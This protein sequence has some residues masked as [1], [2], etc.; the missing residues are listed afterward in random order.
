MSARLGLL[1]SVL[2]C[3]CC[4]GFGGGDELGERKFPIVFNVPVARTSSKILLVEGV[5][6]G[7][8]GGAVDE[9]SFCTITLFNPANLLPGAATASAVL[10]VGSVNL[11]PGA[12]TAA[13]FVLSVLCFP[14]TA[15]VVLFFSSTPGCPLRLP[16]NAIVAFVAFV[17]FFTLVFAFTSAFTS[18]FALP[19]LFVFSTLFFFS[20]AASGASTTA[21]WQSRPSLR[22][23]AGR[24]KSPS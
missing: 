19:A 13:V 2:G 21:P 9:S 18:V 20:T 6:S 3:C 16:S 22:S 12:A 15:A 24:E 17:V 23:A 11:L 14:G 4:D 10:F 8:A 5:T 7:G 1:L